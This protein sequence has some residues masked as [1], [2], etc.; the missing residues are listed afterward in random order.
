MSKEE[1]LATKAVEEEVKTVAAESVEA[2]E[3]DVVDEALS[4]VQDA[5]E[6]VQAAKAAPTVEKF[7]E[8]KPITDLGRKVLAG[9][10]TNIDQ[11]LD[12]GLRIMEPEIVDVLLPNLETDLLLIGQS[13]GKFGGG[14]RRVFRQTQKKTKEGNKPSFAT[15]AIV[16]DRNGHVGMGYGKSKETV[17]AREKA[18]R[19][20]KLNL[21][22]IRR[23]SGAWEDL[24]TEP[25][26]I[27]FA[28]EGKCGSVIAKLMPAP[29]GKGLIAQAET[30]KI[31]SLAGIKDI[32]TKTK[33]K[34]STR[35]NC[36]KAVF[37]ALKQLSR[38]KIHANHIEELKIE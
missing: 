8:W 36:A 23:G 24:S 2:E 1:K 37:E 10:I 38:T 13:K 19:N 17:P 12:K 33:G 3:T 14:A 29:K 30:A 15:I 25:N 5:E 31:L 22:R 16:G 28:V 27:P 6:S 11:I 4:K 9:D 34:T 21:I 32:W 35:I 26:S 7:E 20:A 18:I